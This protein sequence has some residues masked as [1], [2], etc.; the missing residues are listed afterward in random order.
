MGYFRMGYALTFL[1]NLLKWFQVVLLFC[2]CKKR[3]VVPMV[4]SSFQVNNYHSW[5]LKRHAMD[6]KKTNI[7][8]KQ[9]NTFCTLIS[10]FKSYSGLT[11]QIHLTRTKYQVWKLKETQMLRCWSH[12]KFWRVN[13][14]KLLVFVWVLKVP[15]SFFVCFYLLFT[16]FGHMGWYCIFAI[17]DHGQCLTVI[18]LLKGWLSTHQH[19]KDHSQTPNIYKLKDRLLNTGRVRKPK[20][21]RRAKV[22]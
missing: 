22:D 6:F 16:L 14:I 7:F 19:E 4:I 17:H 18:G 3:K 10:N 2:W 12:L 8:K 20:T 5:R 1:W 21:L 9:T 15:H 13:K 11:P